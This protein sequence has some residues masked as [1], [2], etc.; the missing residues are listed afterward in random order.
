[1]V[2]NGADLHLSEHAA[3]GRVLLKNAGKVA[4]MPPA[5]S[6]L[7]PGACKPALVFSDGSEP[8]TGGFNDR[9]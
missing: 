1:M 7:Q 5:V 6:L 2:G 8:R 9:V 3:R 4:V